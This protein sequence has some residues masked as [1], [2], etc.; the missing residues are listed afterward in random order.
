MYHVD[1]NLQR[2]HNVTRHKELSLDKKLKGRLILSETIQE[3][4]FLGNV[5]LLPRLRCYNIEMIL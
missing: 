1:M 3:I 4:S 5:Y 2:F